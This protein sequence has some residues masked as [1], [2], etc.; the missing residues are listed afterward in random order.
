MY[1]ELRSAAE[2]LMRSERPGHT[3]SPTALL[4]EAY[5][6]LE[7]S[8]DAAERIPDRATYYRYAVR[9]MRQVLVDH[10]RRRS[11]LKR[12]GGTLRLEGESGA[13]PGVGVLELNDLLDRFAALDR[14]RARVAELR[15]FGGLGNAECA[16]H[17]GIA[18]STAASDWAVARA[19]LATRW[20]GDGEP[21]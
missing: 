9:V 14:R 13:F 16:E 5:L 18:R 10:A 8:G 4:H 2:G 12:R 3:L 1:Q 19:W 7:R 20:T 6:R 11:A 21:G 17:L 15:I